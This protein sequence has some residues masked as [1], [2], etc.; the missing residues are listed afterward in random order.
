MFPE[1]SAARPAPLIHTDPSLP[2]GVTFSTLACASVDSLKPMT[3]PVYGRE[4]QC[5]VHPVYTT[6]F[7][8]STPAR[9]ATGPGGAQPCPPNFCRPV[10]GKKPECSEGRQTLPRP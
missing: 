6:P 8:K 1:L 10:R 7:S 2:F 4:S 5:E 9:S 3:Q